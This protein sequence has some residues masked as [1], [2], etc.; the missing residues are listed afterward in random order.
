MFLMDE[1]A[2]MSDTGNPMDALREMFEKKAENA[3][4][5]DRKIFESLNPDA[6]VES[7]KFVLTDEHWNR[8]IRFTFSGEHK[9]TP[10]NSIVKEFTLAE[11]Y[12]DGDFNEYESFEQLIET[13]YEDWVMGL[14]DNYGGKIDYL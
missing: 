9:P 5:F 14:N 12:P 8:K 10:E 3:S 7:S 4:S 1:L 2:K 13:L 6:S 11:E